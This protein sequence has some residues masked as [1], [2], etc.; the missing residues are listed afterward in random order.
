MPGDVERLCMEPLDTDM[1][2]MVRESRPMKPGT[3]MNVLFIL[4][5]IGGVIMLLFI[6]AALF[7]FDLSNV[8]DTIMGLM[9]L[10]FIVFIA[11]L[12]WA[13]APRAHQS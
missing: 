5:I 11:L 12:F 8:V 13:M 7:Q 6:S 10:F 3:R 9:I 1:D 4:P 2:Y